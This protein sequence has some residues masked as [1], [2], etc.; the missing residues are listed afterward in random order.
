MGH[1]YT[2]ARERAAKATLIHLDTAQIEANTEHTRFPMTSNTS[3]LTIF[4][5]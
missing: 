5:A 4:R 1:R 2:G 3:P